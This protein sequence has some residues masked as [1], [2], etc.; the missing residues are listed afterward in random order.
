MFVGQM[1]WTDCVS[2]GRMSDCAS[3]FVHMILL[4]ILQRLVGFTVTHN[5][6]QTYSLLNSTGFSDFEK[7]GITT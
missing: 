5:T 2:A 6:I 7:E 1:C 4:A 3:M